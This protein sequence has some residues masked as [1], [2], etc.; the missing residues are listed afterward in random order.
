MVKTAGFDPYSETNLPNS[1]ALWTVT[2]S[3]LLK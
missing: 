3:G 2:T 1:L